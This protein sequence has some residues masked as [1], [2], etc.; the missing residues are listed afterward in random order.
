MRF[1]DCTPCHVMT[2][3]LTNL[4]CSRRCLFSI[5]LNC[6]MCAH[7]LQMSVHVCRVSHVRFELARLDRGQ[8]AIYSRANAFSEEPR[9]GL[10]SIR[11]PCDRVF[12]SVAG[13]VVLCYADPTLVPSRRIREQ[14][15]YGGAVGKLIPLISSLGTSVAY[16]HLVCLR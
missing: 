3:Q 14:D 15:I 11:S 8:T 9:P 4:R 16:T 6:L 13:V 1:S 2:R 5:P 12:P 10:G 7:P